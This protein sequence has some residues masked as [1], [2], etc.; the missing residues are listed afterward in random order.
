MKEE[1]FEFRELDSGRRDALVLTHP[2][3]ALGTSIEDPY[4][5]FLREHGDRFDVY[6]VE[7]K[8]FYKEQ[9]DTQLN[10]NRVDLP[11]GYLDGLYD[12]TL[13]EPHAGK[14]GNIQDSDIREL[15]ETKERILFGGENLFMCLR[16]GY[17]DSVEKKE[18]IGAETEI[19]ILEEV[20]YTPAADPEG[21]ELMVNLG[22]LKEDDLFL[23]KQE[24]PEIGFKGGK[25]KAYYI[26]SSEGSE[27]LSREFQKNP[28]TSSS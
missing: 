11:A 25:V 14:P 20:S 21:E 19:G 8:N 23:Q 16:R 7:G 15:L 1:L 13:V 22:E 5:E 10:R 17:N 9:E 24:L 2:Y 12:G 26:P 6:F 3:H 18:E 27:G 4:S 28:L